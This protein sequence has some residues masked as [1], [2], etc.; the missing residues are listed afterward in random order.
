M[1]VVVID[2][3]HGD[4]EFRAPRTERMW[5]EETSKLCLWFLFQKCRRICRKTE[6]E[7]TVLL[8]W[9]W[10]VVWPCNEFF[11]LVFLCVTKEKTGSTV[12]GECSRWFCRAGV[13]ER[14][15]GTW[16]AEWWRCSG[17]VSLLGFWRDSQTVG[18]LG[19]AGSQQVHMEKSIDHTGERQYFSGCWMLSLCGKQRP[20]GDLW[21]TSALS[22]VEGNQLHGEQQRM[23][24][25]TNSISSCRKWWWKNKQ[26]S[27]SAV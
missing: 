23:L 1:S 12:W 6:G 24:S 14:V 10:Q 16:Q 11:L 5:Q 21:F 4:P 22:R 27:W 15:D 7:F 2:M 13:R 26:E 17:S 20:T 19:V 8:T 9:W 18:L 3:F 25:S